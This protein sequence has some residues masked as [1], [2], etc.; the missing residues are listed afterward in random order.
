[1]LS[2]LGV[3]RWSSARNVKSI[4]GHREVEFCS[5]HGSAFK[6]ENYGSFR[7]DLKNG[8]PLLLQALA[9]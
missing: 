3:E 4:G 8:G 7:C 1:M 9:C 2:L 6:S 5:C